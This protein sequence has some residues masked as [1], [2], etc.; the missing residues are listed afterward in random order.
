MQAGWGVPASYGEYVDMTQ[1]IFVFILQLAT[2]MCSNATKKV[3][4][5]WKLL[6]VSYLKKY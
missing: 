3:L 1:Y 2:G 6:L 5:N 4:P